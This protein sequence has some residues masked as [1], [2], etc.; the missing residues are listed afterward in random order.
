LL[1]DHSD[2]EPGLRVC[3]IQAANV[4]WNRPWPSGVITY[5]KLRIRDVG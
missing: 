4:G 3:G 2:S 5:R 1:F